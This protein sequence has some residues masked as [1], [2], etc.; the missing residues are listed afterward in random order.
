LNP[1]GTSGIAEG[2]RDTTREKFVDDAVAPG[3]GKSP[4]RISR[5]TPGLSERQSPNAA[6]PVSGPLC[7][8]RWPNPAKSAA[9]ANIE[10]RAAGMI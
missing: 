6:S 7:A 10:R 1:A 2:G 5:L 4:G 3:F 9:A 8:D